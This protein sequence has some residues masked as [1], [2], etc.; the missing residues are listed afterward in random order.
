MIFED[1][2]T[3][4]KIYAE[5]K[6]PLYEEIREMNKGL[7]KYRFKMNMIYLI[8][9]LDEFIEQ[10]RFYFGDKTKEVMPTSNSREYYQMLSSEFEIE[11]EN[12]I[13]YSKLGKYP[14]IESIITHLGFK[15]HNDDSNGVCYKLEKTNSNYK[16]I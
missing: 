10:C 6:K 8:N 12:S 5:E 16:A 15:K 13:F 4:S 3:E 1:G 9:Y 7:S 2:P 14:Q 11:I